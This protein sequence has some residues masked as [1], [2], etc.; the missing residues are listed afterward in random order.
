[1]DASL[2]LLADDDQPSLEALRASLRAAGAQV[3]A[4]RKAAPASQAIDFHRPNAVVVDPELEDGRGWDV[5]HAARRDARVPVLALERVPNETARRSALA[6]GAHEVVAKPFD[7]DEVAARVLA[8]VRLSRPDASRGPVYRHGELV[9]DIAAHSVRIAGR[10]VQVTAQQFAIL[11]ALCEAGGATLARSQLLARIAGLDDEPASERAID[12]HVARL[13]RRLG[14]GRDRPRFIETVYGA[15]Y[16]LAGET[17]HAATELSTSAPEVLDALPEPVLVVDA[18]LT[19]RFANAA[20][21]R[22]L[23]K[24]RDAIV[25]RHCGE[26]LGCRAVTGDPLE[27]RRCLGRAVLHDGRVLR[28]VGAIVRGTDGELAVELSYGRAGHEGKASLLAISLRPRDATE[29]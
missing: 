2:V 29:Q 25:G 16:R 19:V 8:L 22:L 27:G 28:N 18:T 12:L 10:A 24:H 14:D 26:V 9:V 23:G 1:M 3:I 5:L 4:C 20:A 7:A 15:G 11:R 13:R 21:E 6:A 17:P